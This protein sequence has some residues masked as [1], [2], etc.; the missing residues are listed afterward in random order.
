MRVHLQDLHQVVEVLNP[1]N[2]VQL[3]EARYPSGD[4]KAD[5]LRDVDIALQVYF[6][7]SAG[8][9]KVEKAPATEKPV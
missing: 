6:G 1:Q 9:P 8:S 7:A 5:P 3:D 4:H 2:G